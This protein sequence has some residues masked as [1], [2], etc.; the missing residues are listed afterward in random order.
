VFE[1]QQDKVPNI[2]LEEK[3]ELM[4]L[5]M[6]SYFITYVDYQHLILLA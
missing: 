4:L 2:L 1:Y 6:Y 5:Y 3:K